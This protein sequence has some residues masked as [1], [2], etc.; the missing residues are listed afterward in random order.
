MDETGPVSVKGNGNYH[1]QGPHDVAGS[2]DVHYKYANGIDLHCHSGGENGVKFEGT[3]GWLF[4]SR[5][6][7]EASDPAILES[8]L[9]PDDV[10]LYNTGDSPNNWHNHYNDWLECIKTRERPICD[11][12]V[13]HRSA[14]VCHLGNIAMMLGRKLE[15]DPQKEQFVNDPVANKHL[16]RPM[17]APWHI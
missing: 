5:G 17:R 9:G 3:D 8:E 4:V 16:L 14:T 6:R 10:R 1:Q 15:W 7:I 2:F 13:G 12:S 11:V